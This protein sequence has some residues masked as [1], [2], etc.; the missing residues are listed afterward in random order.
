MAA[1]EIKKKARRVP[2]GFN[3]R[4]KTDQVELSAGTYATVERAVKFH[5]PGQW[6]RS[7]GGLYGPTELR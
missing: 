3:P 6:G 4:T 1:T 7:T 5:R 2:L